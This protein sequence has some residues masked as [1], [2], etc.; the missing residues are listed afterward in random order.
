MIGLI[1]LQM[2]DSVRKRQ[3]LQ[4]VQSSLK[5]EYHVLRRIEMKISS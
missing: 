2:A 5:V 3:I 4:V 1:R